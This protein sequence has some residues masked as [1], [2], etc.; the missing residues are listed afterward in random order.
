[1]SF[2][3]PLAQFAAASQGESAEDGGGSESAI[4]FVP[5]LMQAKHRMM[6]MR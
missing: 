3:N 4:F 1:M 5:H 2:S 6:T